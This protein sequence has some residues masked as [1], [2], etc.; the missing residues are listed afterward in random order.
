MFESKAIGP[1]Y[2]VEIGTAGLAPFGFVVAGRYVVGNLQLVQD[3]LCLLQRGQVSLF[4][5]IAGYKDEVDSGGGIH[6][7]HG[8]LQVLHSGSGMGDVQIGEQRKTKI[9]CLNK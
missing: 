3:G 8:T 9:L 6:L 2:L 7:I 1:E 5:D 4:G